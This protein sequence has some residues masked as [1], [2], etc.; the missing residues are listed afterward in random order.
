MK[1]NLK[2]LNIDI[3]VNVIIGILIQYSLSFNMNSEPTS[4]FIVGKDFRKLI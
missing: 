3:E 1:S 2:K 4:I